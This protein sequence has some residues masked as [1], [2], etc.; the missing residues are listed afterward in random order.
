MVRVGA[1]IKEQ[2]ERDDRAVSFTPHTY[3]H[4]HT[5]QAEASLYNR[6]DRDWGERKLREG[7]KERQILVRCFH[8]KTKSYLFIT[9]KYKFI[10]QKHF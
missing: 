9:C 8:I 5:T 7:G 4:T 10:F 1:E 2:R 3:T 6:K